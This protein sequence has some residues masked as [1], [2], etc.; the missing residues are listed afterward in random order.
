MSPV[1]SSF[2]LFFFCSYFFFHFI[3]NTS[4]TV[5]CLLFVYFTEAV[6]CC[7]HCAFKHIFIFTRGVCEIQIV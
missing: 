6:F 2:P 4:L 7:I 5:L 3:L 1:P